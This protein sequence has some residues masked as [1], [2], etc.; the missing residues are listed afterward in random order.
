MD[1]RIMDYLKDTFLPEFIHDHVLAPDSLA[2]QITSTLQSAFSPLLTTMAP[3]LDRLT[4]ALY[5]S[6]DIVVLGFL[7]LILVLV[8]QIM[9]WLRRALVF[10]TR[11]A[12]NLLFYAAIVGLAA[13]VWQRGLEASWTDAVALGGTLVKYVGW[14]KD[15]WLREYRRYEEQGQK[16][17]GYSGARAQGGW[18]GR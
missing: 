2:R 13:S 4:Q 11:M 12:F 1:S 7:A 5:S 6:P 17:G 3:L 18:R 9:S 15:I 8:F 16:R 14:V 10:W